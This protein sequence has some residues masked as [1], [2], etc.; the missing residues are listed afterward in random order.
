MAISLWRDIAVMVDLN[1]GDVISLTH[2]KMER[3]P[4]GLQMKSTGY[5]TIQKEEKVY[6]TATVIGVKKGSSPGW[7]KV[8]LASGEDVKIKEEM[9]EPYRDGFKKNKLQLKL[10]MQG[11]VVTEICSTSEQ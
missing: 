1:P 9:W 10:K 4:Y 6:E 2:M 5:T 11:K 8:L 7:L 3:S